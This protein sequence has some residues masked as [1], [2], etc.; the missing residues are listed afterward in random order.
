MRARLA[1]NA[2]ALGGAPLGNLFAA[3]DEAGAEGVMHAAL[4]SGVTYFD[5]A[6]HYGHGLSEHRMGRVLRSVARERFVLS[7]KVGRL[8]TADPAAP[9]D[10]HGYVQTLPFVQRYDYTADGVRRSLDDS[11]QR[12]GLA[13][14][15]LVFA[16]DIDRATHDA[17]HP[18]RWRDLLEGGL[19]TLAAL[20]AEGRI[21]GY[22]L[23]VNEVEICLTALAHADLDVIL[24]AGRYTLA[25]QEALPRLLPECVRR[26]VTVV[27]GGPF[28]SGILAS[29]ATPG[30]GKVPYYNYAPAPPAVI[31]R[32][33]AIE[34]A[35]REFGVALKAAALQFPRGHP[36]V[37]C[38]LA[39]ARSPGEVM[40]NARLAR[41]PVPAEFWAALAERRLI[42]PSS[43]LPGSPC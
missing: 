41:E 21:A 35:C 3:L 25:D 37:G 42:D 27:L 18:Q 17:A 16:H 15:D 13:R 1:A 43:P 12:L 10:Q 6:P 29:G 2:P 38:V 40:E 19:P 11:L 5:T 30:E 23:G 8:L 4:A 14:V 33:A 22:G 34:A 36:A 39:G 26:G 20:K 24:L 28:N 7:T 32:V 9:R 31:A